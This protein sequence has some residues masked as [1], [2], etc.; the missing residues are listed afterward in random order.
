M[1]V[2]GLVP[3]RGVAVDGVAIATPDAFSCHISGF[4]QIMHDPLCGAFGNPNALCAV[5]EPYLAVTSDT[6]QDLRVVREEGPGPP[7][8]G[9]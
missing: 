1:A 3:H 9:T 6:E 7:Q 5:T 4:D 2:L 8:Q